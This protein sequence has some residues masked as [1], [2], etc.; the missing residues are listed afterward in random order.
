VTVSTLKALFHWYKNY[1][2]PP[3]NMEIVVKS[4][5][6]YGSPLSNFIVVMCTSNQYSSSEMIPLVYR[7]QFGYN[8]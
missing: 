5:A 1:T 7:V 2:N 6:L 3:R 8:S 4:K